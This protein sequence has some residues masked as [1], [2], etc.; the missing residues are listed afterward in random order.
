MKKRHVLVVDDDT[1]LRTTIS[2]ALLLNDF[3]V[4]QATNGVEAL[5]SIATKR[6]DFVML[7]VNMPEMDGMECLSRIKE[8]DPSII[9]IIMTAYSNIEDAVRATKEG[10]YNY[11][12]KP[13]KHN[14]LVDMV[15]KALEAQ[16][17]VHSM[18]FSAPVVEL[19]R[20]QFVGSSSEMQKIFGI[21]YKLAKVDTSVLIRGESGTGKELVARA[22]HFNSARKDEK[23]VAINCSSI[24]ETLFESELFG[25][26]KGAFT[27]AT[28]RQIGKFQ[29][30][31]GGTI[32]L[33]EIGDLPLAMQ[34]KLLRVLQERNFIPV[35]ATRE[36]DMNARIIAATN[37][38]LEEMIK[39]GSFREDL[40]YRLNVI[41]IYL[42]PLRERK[43]DIEKLVHH[44]IGKFNQLHG[45]AISGITREAMDV[46]L[47]HNWPGNIRELENV[48]EHSFVIENGNELSLASL[49]ETLLESTKSAP[50]PFLGS[51]DNADDISFAGVLSAEDGDLDYRTHK[52]RFEKD[53]IIAALKKYKGKIN[54]T[55][56]QANIPKKTLLRKLQKYGINPEE[57]RS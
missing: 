40:F 3:E 49:P 5:R 36:I 37:R 29:Y 11:L 15:E 38:D 1:E 46:L 50:P 56:L 52:E 26:E 31:E 34:V 32:F 7:D 4:A 39:E 41:P 8:L 9:V 20:A 43:D 12:P 57:F 25:H 42:P 21:I 45:N 28:Q 44:F 47:K 35:G 10:A 2:E 51:S 16:K 6:P 27:G 30:A 54:Q 48:I 53:F 55:A 14:E 18:A 22:I 24:P 19:D 33:D 23:F 13:I 17:M